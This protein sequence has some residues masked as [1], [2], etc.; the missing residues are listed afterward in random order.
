MSDADPDRAA[1]RSLRRHRAVAT[2]L[3]L[4]MAALTIGAHFLP[5]GR[6]SDLLEAAARAGFVGGIADWFAVTALFRH[7][8]GL[9]IPHTAIIPREKARLGAAL[10]RF[11]SRH[12]LAEQ[13]IGRLLTRFDT[14]SLLRTVLTDTKVVRPLAQALAGYVPRVLATVEDGRGRRLMT[15]L[16]PRLIGGANAGRVAARALR[17]LVEGGQH[18]AM[19]SFT[20][21]K[22]REALRDREADLRALIEGRVREQGGRLVGWALG[23][24]VATRILN[25]VNTEFDRMGP[26]ASPVRDAFDEWVR[27]EIERMEQDP[28]RAAEIG[29]AFRRLLG[30]PTVQAWGWDVWGR[31]RAALEADAMQ[32]DGR[33]AMVLENAFRNLGDVVATDA[34]TQARV[35]RMMEQVLHGLLP[36]AQPQIAAFIGDVVAGWDTKTITERLELRVGR[37]LQYVRMNGT[38]VGFLVGGL[39]Y[40]AL[41]A[42]FGARGF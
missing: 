27:H 38:I 17:A 34:P 4:L 40:A 20:L 18:Q 28:A 15:R 5:P 6:W 31:L 26:D 10:G 1:R 9:P 23:A 19:L 35:Q 36:A 3:L 37:D 8:L 11:V 33:V 21:D 30:H 22:L 42:A 32:P 7:P 39:A 14:A 25:T 2:L 12:V 41:L 13:E 16:V 29:R 24:T